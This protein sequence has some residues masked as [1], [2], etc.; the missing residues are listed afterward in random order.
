MTGRRVR[1]EG[2]ESDAARS[3][4]REDDTGEQRRGQTEMRIQAKG[5]VRSKHEGVTTAGKDVRWC[6]I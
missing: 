2:H 1:A 4:Q 3:E 6:A 5:R